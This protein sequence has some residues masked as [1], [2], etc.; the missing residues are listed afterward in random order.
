MDVGSVR[1]DPVFDGVL[2]SRP[3][4]VLH[5]PGVVDPWLPHGDLLNA[6]GELEMPVGGFLIRTGQRIVLVD[7]GLGPVHGDG[8]SAGALLES[9][10][11]LG[12]TTDAITDVVLTH[13][14]FDHV[15]WVAQKGEVVFPNAVYRC[16]RNDWDHFVSAPGADPGAIRKLAPIAHRLEPFTADRTVAPGVDV[17]A[18][19]GHTPGSTIVL[20]SSNHERAILLGDVVHCPMELTE[21]GWQ[22]IYDVDPRLARQTREALMRELDGSTIPAAAAHFPGMRFGRLLAD[23]GQSRW[24]FI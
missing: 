6:S 10:A 22:T 24:M 5:R 9:L 11:T 8:F 23:S 18:A 4:V 21:P 15:G 13:L 14:H 19:P 2:T 7:A 20:V 3:E 16:H 1:I 17:R 12:V